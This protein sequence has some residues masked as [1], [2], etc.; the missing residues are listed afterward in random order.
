MQ[1][2]QKALLEQTAIF[3]AVLLLARL[4]LQVFFSYKF[5]ILLKALKETF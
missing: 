2:L 1:L 4:P 3:M 5:I